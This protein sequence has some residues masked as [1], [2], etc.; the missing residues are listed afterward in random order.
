MGSEAEPLQNLRTGSCELL[1]AASHRSPQTPFLPPW[2][3]PVCHV[4][5]L[6]LCLS[7]LPA[8]TTGAVLGQENS[9]LEGTSSPQFTDEQT[10]VDLGHICYRR[11]LESPQ[12]GSSEKPP[13]HQ[14]GKVRSRAEVS[15]DLRYPPQKFG[16]VRLLS[17]ALDAE[18][19]RP[20]R[21]NKAAL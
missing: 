3:Q 21:I 14:M 6:R 15:P 10:E 11:M 16:D 13:W 18:V 4:A 2:L 20:D 19:S 5:W 1:L 8:L 17:W 9:L 12:V 7:V